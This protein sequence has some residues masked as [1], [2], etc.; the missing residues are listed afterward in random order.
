[1][2][3][4]EK[5]NN[6]ETQ[7]LMSHDDFIVFEPFS[8]AWST[9]AD[10]YHRR[11]VLESTT[12]ARQRHQ[13]LG[14]T[15]SDAIVFPN[16]EDR[17]PLHFPITMGPVGDRSLSS[18]TVWARP[19]TN[20]STDWKKL[21]GSHSDDMEISYSLKMQALSPSA[22]YCGFDA[23]HHSLRAFLYRMEFDPMKRRAAR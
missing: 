21:L 5:K 15:L 20:D 4:I 2:V 12:S 19:D 23:H 1:M 7:K 10:H 3:K 17:K 6:L 22:H 9:M 11:R 13:N 14:K 8:Q 18:E 16:P